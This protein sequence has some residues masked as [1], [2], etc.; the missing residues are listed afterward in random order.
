MTAEQASVRLR[1]TIFARPA[2]VYRAWLEPDLLRWWLAPLGF[3]VTHVEVERARRWPLL[4]LGAGRVRRD[5]R[6]RLRAGRAHHQPAARLPLALRG[7]GRRRS[8]AAG[9]APDGLPAQNVGQRHEAPLIHDGLHALA[10]RE[11]REPPAR[12]PSHV[13]REELGEIWNQYKAVG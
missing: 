3:T 4:G 10:P 2:E 1:R 5:R 6:L 9:L 11:R 12:L 13:P 7:L 8:A